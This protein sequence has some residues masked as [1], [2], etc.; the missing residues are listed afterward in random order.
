MPEPDAP[1]PLSPL[2][3][4]LDISQ[5]HYWQYHG[6]EA[7]LGCKKPITASHDEDLFIAVHQICEV[8]FHQ[9]LIDLERVLAALTTALDEANPIG[10]TREACYFLERVLRLYT[11]VV[12]TM[13]IL[14][15]M[16]AFVEFR[17][18]IGP[19]SGFQSFQFRHLEIMSGVQ[20]PYWQGGTSDAHGQRHIAELEFERR[21]GA[22]VAAWFARH[23]SDSL[24]FYYQKLLDR[25]VETALTEKLA[26]LDRHPHAA[27]LLGQLRYYE[28]LQS[29]FHR[30][31]LGLAIR[32][33]AIVDTSTGTGGTSFNRYLSRYSREIAPLFPGLRDRTDAVFGPDE[34]PAS[35]L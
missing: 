6:L 14:G 10:E 20:M 25:T 31:H 1:Q 33:L 12:D 15:T 29:R 7:L 23:R 4:E 13:P 26:T 8:A 22:D 17:T 24:A 27:P 32:Q 28:V 3:P 11:V 5:N 19:T 21:Y 9:M 35:Q 16:R 18:S 2:D 34:L 30:A